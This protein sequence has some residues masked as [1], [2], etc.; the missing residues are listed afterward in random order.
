MGTLYIAIAHV[1]LANGGNE[2][3]VALLFQIIEYKQLDM[4]EITD[5]LTC[6]KLLQQWHVPI[7]EQSDDPVLYEN[8]AF[9]KSD[10][11]KDIKR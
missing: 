11:E 4:T 9:K 7:K 3:I 6:P 10:N 2:N 8:I 5:H 1:Q